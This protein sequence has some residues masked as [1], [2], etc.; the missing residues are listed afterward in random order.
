MQNLRLMLSE[1]KTRLKEALMNVQEFDVVAEN[2]RS[3]IEARSGSLD[4][5]GDLSVD[6]DDL[7]KK[8]HDIKVNICK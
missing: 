3:E 4:R 5:L 2:F 8:I 6:W 7:K 1:R